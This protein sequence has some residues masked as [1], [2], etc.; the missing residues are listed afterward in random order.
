MTYK[1][2]FKY[3]KTETVIATNYNID[4]KFVNFYT[5]CLSEQI[6]V[7]SYSTKGL[8]SITSE[9]SQTEFSQSQELRVKKLQRILKKD[10]I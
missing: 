6:T 1:I 8:I 10:I 5:I 3:K 7:A 9:F 4:N 2:H